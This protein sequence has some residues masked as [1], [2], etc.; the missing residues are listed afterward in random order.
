MEKIKLYRSLE[1]VFKL[2]ITCTDKFKPAL[3]QTPRSTVLQSTLHE[4]PPRYVPLWQP[5][6]SDKLFQRCHSANQQAQQLAT[7]WHAVRW[8][9]SPSLCR[10]GKTEAAGQEG[11]SIKGSRPQDRGKAA[12]V[13][14]FVRHCF[15]ISVTCL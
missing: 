3:S 8:F 6:S 12:H 2:T 1:N 13:L 4:P 11:V 10:S 14:L 5:H 15:P 9:L 7:P